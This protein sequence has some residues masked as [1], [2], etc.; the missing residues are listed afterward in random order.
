M[1]VRAASRQLGCEHINLLDL[2]RRAKQFPARTIN[3]S[4]TFPAR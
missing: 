3:A 2:R 4:A 1:V